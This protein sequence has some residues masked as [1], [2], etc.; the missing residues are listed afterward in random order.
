MKNATG[1]FVVLVVALPGFS[2]VAT[3]KN[4][5]PDYYPLKA[6]AKWT[7]QVD[8]GTGQKTQVTNQLAKI[9]TIDGKELA[10]METMVGGNVAATEHLSSSSKG[11]F[12]HRYNGVEVTP[13]LCIM[14]YPF[15][16]GE[17][18]EAEPMIGPQ[19]LKMTIRSGK[20]EELT[21][22][23]GK[24]KT[25]SVSVETYVNGVRINATSWYAPDIGV[26][27]QDTDV[28]EKKIKLELVKFE[29]GK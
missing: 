14:K 10:R 15:K 20:A 9:E 8:S 13:A 21:V 3:N 12:R 25:V 27:K 5:L 4:K 18:W 2:Q 1:I 11:V 24:Y 6:G 22:P 16:E 23:A 7:Y 29:P 26:V 28:G 17:S 19:K